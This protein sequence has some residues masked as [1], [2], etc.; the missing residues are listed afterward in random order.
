MPSAGKQVAEEL[1]SALSRALRGLCG[2]EAGHVEDLRRMPGGS[3]RET[4]SF[5]GSVPGQR[6]RLLVLRRD[7]PGAPSSGMARE[8]RLLRAASTAGVPVPRVVAA[9]DDRSLL[10]SPFV[11]MEHVEGETIPRRILRDPELAGA[12]AALTS[13]CAR[14]LAAVHRIPVDEVGD[15]A[16]GDEVV[17]YRE[18]LWELGEPHPVFE[19]A[20]R[21]LEANRPPATGLAVVHGDFRIGNLI[22]GPGGLRAVLDWELAHVGDPVEDLGWLC[23][24]AWRFGSPLPVGGFGGYEELLDA[25]GEAGGRRV[26]LGRLRWWELFGT[27]RWGIICIVQAMTHL[28][29]AVRSVELA[30]IGRRVCEVEWDVLDLLEELS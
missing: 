18:L 29:G 23:V 16:N 27:L 30:T 5:Y 13:Q 6:R 19:V 15:L 11:V 21:W 10:G 8:L 20:F 28:G 3:S 2:P 4:W 12:R 17:R 24:K 25:Y 1:A 22:V 9:S 26:E 14:A 7:P